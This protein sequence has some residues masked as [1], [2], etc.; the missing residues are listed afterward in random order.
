MSETIAEKKDTQKNNVIKDDSGN[1]FLILTFVL[2]IVLL[3]LAWIFMSPFMNEM[4][5]IYNGWVGQGW[6][7]QDSYQRMTIVK[8]GWMAIPVLGIIILAVILI[9]RSYVRHDGG[10]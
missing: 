5:G 7:S 4:F 9:I 10:Y 3:G 8:Y 6:V 2:A 1:A